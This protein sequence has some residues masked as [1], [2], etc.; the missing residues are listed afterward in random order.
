MAFALALKPITNTIKSD[1][2]LMVSRSI[3]KNNSYLNS[4]VKKEKVDE[5]DFFKNS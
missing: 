3:N 1:S 4:V 5:K 2:K